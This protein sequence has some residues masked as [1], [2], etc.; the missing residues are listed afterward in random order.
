MILDCFEDLFDEA[1]ERDGAED[2]DFDSLRH[3]IKAYLDSFNYPEHVMSKNDDPDYWKNEVRRTGEIRVRK[4]KIDTEFMWIAHEYYSVI[5]SKKVTS[6]EPVSE[7]DRSELIEKMDRLS[8][9]ILNYV[10]AGN[11]VYTRSQARRLDKYLYRKTRQAAARIGVA[12]PKK[13]ARERV[14]YHDQV[15]GKVIDTPKQP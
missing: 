8:G 4:D 2:K 5:Y 14:T 9:H 7:D 13:A 1:K 12:D 11:N 10:K 3:V 15:T 6:G